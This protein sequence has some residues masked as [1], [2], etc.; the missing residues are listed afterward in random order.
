[1]NR[2][3]AILTIVV[4]ITLTGVVPVLGVILVG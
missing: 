4:L 3:A 2:T 1:M